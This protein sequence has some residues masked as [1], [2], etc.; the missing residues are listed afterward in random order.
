MTKGASS[1]SLRFKRSIE[2]IIILLVL[3]AAS[4]V[5]IFP[6]IWMTL[7]AFKTS[8]EIAR[9]PPTFLP[10]NI[11]FS[12]FYEAIKVAKLDR[13]F[14]NSV[15]VSLATVVL[16]LLT[17]SLA[18]FAFA[19]YDFKGKNIMFTALMATLILPFFIVVIPQY[20]LM[21]WFGWRNTY[22]ALIVPSAV[23]TYGIFLMRQYILTVPDE[24]LDSARIDG[25][26]EIGIYWRIILPLSKPAMSV[27]ALWTFMTSWNSFF[28]P[29]IVI[30][31]RDMF[32]IPLA[33][34]ALQSSAIG[35]RYYNIAMAGATL[36]VLPLL[37]FTILLH[38]WLIR[39]M[40]G[41]TGLKF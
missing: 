31:S 36:A 23:S 7:S 13:A 30:D 10:E 17:S 40:A 34:L 15:V 25:C 9:V 11:V 3:S 29:F 41:A 21:V 2:Q 16:V 33:L 12:N 24:L 26:S 39:G 4:L 14:L 27:L 22:W 28:W 18:G 5:A 35:V 1:H 37:V 8:E 38:K 20:L 6:F 19:K 32:T